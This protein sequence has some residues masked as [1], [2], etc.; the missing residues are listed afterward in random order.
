[1]K[2]REVWCAAFHGVAKSWIQQELDTTAIEQQPYKF[3]VYNVL[4]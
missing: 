4:I 3:K 1:M 2:D